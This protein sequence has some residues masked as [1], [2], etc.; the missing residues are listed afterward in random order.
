MTFTDDDL[1]RW[2]KTHW[3]DDSKALLIR[4]EAAEAYAE[5]RLRFCSG[6]DGEKEKLEAWRKACGK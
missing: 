1:K 4:L 6:H 2:K 3:G 5:F